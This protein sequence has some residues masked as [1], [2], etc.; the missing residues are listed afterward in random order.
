MRARVAAGLFERIAEW[1]G[2]GRAL[3]P[4]SCG[5]NAAKSKPADLSTT[6]SLFSQASFL[7][8]RAKLFAAPP[9]Q[10]TLQDLDRYQHLL[11]IACTAA[12]CFYRSGCCMFTAQQLSA[13]QY[14]MLPKAS[15]LPVCLLKASSD[16]DQQLVL[17]E[18]YAS[19]CLDCQML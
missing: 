13:Q 10:L 17:N 9:E 7:G 12:G 3:Y 15:Q 19:H 18:L 11:T 16:S 1:N 6:A 2:F 14:A 8:I 5:L 4:W